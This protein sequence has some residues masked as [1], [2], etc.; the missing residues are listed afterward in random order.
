MSVPDIKNLG[1]FSHVFSIFSEEGEP[2][3]LTP[4]MV[5][6]EFPLIDP[7]AAPSAEGKAKKE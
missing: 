2:I 5:L 6:A 1:F 7:I 4:E 3:T